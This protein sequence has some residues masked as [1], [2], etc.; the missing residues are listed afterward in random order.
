MITLHDL[1]GEPITIIDTSRIVAV[2]QLKSVP[3]DR[4][5]NLPPCAKR[6]AIKLN[7][8]VFVV[9]ESHDEVMSLLG[10]KNA[11]PA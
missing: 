11:K 8:D 6:T 10:V 3:P 1:D 9:R 5:L 7:D 4:S 2:Q